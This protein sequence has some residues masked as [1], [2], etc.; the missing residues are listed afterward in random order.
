MHT[1][2]ELAAPD[3]EY[4]SDGK[5]VPR[6]EVMPTITPEDRVGIVMG[7]GAEGIGAGNFVL[8]C[9]TVFY[10]RLR[11]RKGDFFEYPNYYTFQATSN[12]A[13]YRMLDIYPDHKNVAI[14]PDAER[15]VRALNDRAISILLVPG[16]TAR[17]TD[18][19]DITRRSAE[20]RIDHCFEYAIGGQSGEREF[21][22]GLPRQPAEDWYT[23][24]VDSLEDSSTTNRQPVV[25][26]SDGRITQRFRCVGLGTALSR[27]PIGDDHR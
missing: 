22:I 13:D 16:N 7:T 2:E 23:A 10:D 12:P 25:E 1:S 11:A 15:L 19:E 21:S 27:L 17:S 20:R 24:T 18:I 8:S 14:E 4:R 9:V 3:F 5:P 6:G 26:S